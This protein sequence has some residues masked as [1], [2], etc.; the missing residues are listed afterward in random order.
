MSFD[1]EAVG[2]NTFGFIDI[3]IEYE[4]L[5]ARLILLYVSAKVTV[6]V[7]GVMYSFNSTLLPGAADGVAVVIPILN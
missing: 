5:E 2:T 6:D 7:G 3:E 1:S 4:G